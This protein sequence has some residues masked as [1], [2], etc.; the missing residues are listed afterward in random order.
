M[1][2]GAV[3]AEE[4]WPDTLAQMTPVFSVFLHYRHIFLF[5]VAVIV[6][7]RRGDNYEMKDILDLHFFKVT[8]NPTSDREVKKV[9][10]LPN[11]FTSES[12]SLHP[13]HTWCSVL[14]KGNLHKFCNNSCILLGKLWDLKTF[15]S[16]DPVTLEGLRAG[17]GRKG[18][19]FSFM[20]VA[21][22]VFSPLFVC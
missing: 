22:A 19:D 10:W 7:K 5:D 3:N 18:R 15:T 20:F 14:C 9:S 4:D 6:C 8:N 13:P 1:K 21:D 11:A 2:R 12:S 16:C 17:W